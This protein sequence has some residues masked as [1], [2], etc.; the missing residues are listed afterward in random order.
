VKTLD[1]V[2]YQ[3]RKD[4]ILQQARHLFSTKGYAE[5]S[6]D[7]IA[8]SNHMQKAS[9]YH[10]FKSKQQILQEMIEL[11]GGRWLGRMRTVPLD[12]DFKESLM[13]VAKTF[14]QNL[15]DPAGREFFRIIYFE[16][17]KN[18]AIFKAFKESP[19]YKQG[20]I[21]EV[22]S[23]HFGDRLSRVNIA[24][25]VTQF[26]GGL[27]HYARMSRLHQENMCME[28]FSDSQYLDQFIGVFTRGIAGV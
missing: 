24:M 21:F 2:L 4:A 7:D 8:H 16:S 9:L 25:L 17:S 10:Y 14:L 12:V 1:P 15:D 28:K 6:M 27:I 26:V 11:E 23:R 3:I 13:H 5:T 22:F 20:P 19:T 18:P